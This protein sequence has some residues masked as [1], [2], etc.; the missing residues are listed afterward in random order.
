MVTI[1]FFAVLKK[2]CD[3]EE[4]KLSISGP[5]TVKELIDL[6][7]KEVPNIRTIMK[8]SRAM[9]AVNQEMVDENHMLEDGDEIALLPPFAGG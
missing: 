5:I 9:L 1:R 8:E 4:L 3:R 7:E 6:A 2:L